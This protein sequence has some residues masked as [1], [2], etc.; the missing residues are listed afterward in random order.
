M[1]SEQKGEKGCDRAYVAIFILL[2][3]LAGYAVYSELARRGLEDSLSEVRLRHEQLRGEL[4]KLRSENN[5]L[6]ASI[7]KQREELQ[8]QIEELKQERDEL[9]QQVEDLTA[10]VYDLKARIQELEL[11]IEVIQG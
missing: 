3:I 9:K 2:V 4:A 11:E 10:L 1:T 8:G 5:D 6:F 7:Y